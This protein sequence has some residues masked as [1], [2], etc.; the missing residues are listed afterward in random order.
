MTHRHKR[1]ATEEEIGKACAARGI[2]RSTIAEAWI[3][4]HDEVELV[5]LGFVDKIAVNLKESPT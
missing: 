4:Q 3:D 2:L 5:L 1:R